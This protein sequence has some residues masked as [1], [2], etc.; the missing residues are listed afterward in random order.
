MHRWLDSLADPRQQGKVVYPLRL[1]V[2]AVLLQRLSGSPSGRRLEDDKRGRPLLLD[3]L[4]SIAGTRME[5][6]PHSDTI[7]H[8]MEGL[9]P[10]ELEGVLVRMASR[11][12]RSR[13][14]DCMRVR[15]VKR[16]EGCFL[17]AV[18][19]VTVH[20][21]RRRLDHSIHRT[22]R[23]GEREY[24]VAKLQASL[25]CD[26]RIRIP[27]MV[28]S[29]ENEAEYDKQD[30]E[31]KAAGRLLERLKAAFPR[32]RFVILLDG[33]YLC[34]RVLD[35]CRRS[36]WHYSITIN[37]GASAF[38]DKAE[39]ALEADGRRVFRGD[40]P[41]TGLSREVSYANGLKHSFGDTEFTLNAIRMKTQGCKL[42]Y[43][44][45][46]HVHKDEAEA[47]LDAV[48]RRRWQIEEQFKVGKRHGLEL[49][50]AFGN[51]GNAAH[52]FYLVAQLAQTCLELMLHSGLFRR[53]QMMQN[54]DRITRVI[55]APMLEWYRSIAVVMD[56]LRVSLMTRPLSDIDMTGWRLGFSSA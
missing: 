23:D 13:V 20:T 24:M 53:L 33:L 48:S 15:G 25:V 17:V 37:E 7:K 12:I 39:R 14:L 56:R 52:N 6:I 19:G 3:N 8:L 35:I 36:K 54:R 55:D 21:S 5:H 49:E 51:T 46:A 22:S 9:R 41:R 34:E 31:L 27:L 45:S 10:C 16:L 32:T 1:L 43:A 30:C 26:G 2:L 47:L 11:L 28:E 18:D 44:V 29:I 4:N 40:D 50:H 42:L 38:L